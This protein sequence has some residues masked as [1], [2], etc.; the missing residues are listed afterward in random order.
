LRSYR[1]SKNRAGDYVSEVTPEALRAAVAK[2]T[3]S[4]VSLKLT[5]GDLLE[6]PH[7]DFVA[8]APQPAR[9]VIVFRSDGGFEVV[10][11]DEIA[12]VCIGRGKASGG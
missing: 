5:N 4:R 7:P 12:A 10:A 3:K 8:F 9:E 6:V 1:A 11:L 2:A